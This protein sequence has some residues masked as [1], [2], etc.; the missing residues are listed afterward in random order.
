M[1]EVLASGIVP[2]KL[3]RSLFSVMCSTRTPPISAIQGVT[4]KRSSNDNAT[5]SSLL[6]MVSGSSTP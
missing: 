6:L 4:L 5:V 3:V 2:S 1:C